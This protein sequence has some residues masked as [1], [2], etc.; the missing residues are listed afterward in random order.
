M[1][2]NVVTVSSIDV[3]VVQLHSPNIQASIQDDSL[4]L[5]ISWRPHVPENYCVVLKNKTY[6]IDTMGSTALVHVRIV[7][8]AMVCTTVMLGVKLPTIHGGSRSVCTQTIPILGSHCPCS[9]YIYI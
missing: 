3:V 1:Y 7:E 8:S 9:R 2:H 6:A 5:Y 4:E